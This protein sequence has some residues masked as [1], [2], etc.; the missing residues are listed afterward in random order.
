MVRDGPAADLLLTCPHGLTLVG[1]DA[2]AVEKS[3]SPEEIAYYKGR[4]IRLTAKS[5]VLDSSVKKKGLAK[6]LTLE[7][8]DSV[9]RACSWAGGQFESDLQAG[10][11]ALLIGRAKKSE[12]KRKREGQADDEEETKSNNKKDKKKH[13]R[14]KE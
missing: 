14:K 2:L 7:W 5:V 13:K 12:S 6:T 10:Y 3:F 8:I 11:D 4:T 1:F 9:F